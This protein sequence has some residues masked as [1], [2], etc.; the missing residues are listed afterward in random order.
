[1]YTGSDG[2]SHIEELRLP[3]E[4]VFQ[5]RLPPGEDIIFR[6]KPM[7]GFHTA[8]RRQYTV[9]LTGRVEIGFGDGT[10]QQLGPGDM[11]LAEDLTGQGHTTTIVEAPW[12]TFAVPLD[13]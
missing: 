4:D 1:M 6:R 11:M 10:S 7:P 3:T 13:Y 5:F 2:Q 8:P 12:L 9:T